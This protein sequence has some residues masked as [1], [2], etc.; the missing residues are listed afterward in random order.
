MDTFDFEIFTEEEIEQLALTDYRGYL[1]VL[2]GTDTARNTRLDR[3]FEE[4]KNGQLKPF[5]MPKN[6]KIF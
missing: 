2:F 3:V 1:P 6:S 4:Y 5:E